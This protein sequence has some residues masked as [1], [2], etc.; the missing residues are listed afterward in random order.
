MGYGTAAYV[1]YVN[2]AED[3]FSSLVFAKARV[4]PLKPV[5]IPRLELAAA[6]LAVRVSRMVMRGWQRSFN[7]VNFWTDSAIVLYYINNKN[8]RFH[9]FVANR[10]SE[11][12]EHTR[13]KQWRHVGSENNPADK[14]SRGL[15]DV[16]SAQLWLDGPAFLRDSP[17]LWPKCLI[18]EEVEGAEEKKAA[19]HMSNVHKDTSFL[20]VFGR[21]STWTGLLRALAW[22]MRYKTYWMVMHRPNRGDSVR[23]GR[24]R[25]DEIRKAEKDLIILVQAEALSSEAIIAGGASNSSLQASRISKLRPRLINGLLCVGGRLT[26][27]SLTAESKHPIILPR[28]HFVTDLLIRYYHVMEGHAG[29]NHVLT[30][31]RQRFWILHGAETVKRTIRRCP[32]CRRQNAV[33]MRQLMAPLPAVRVREGWHP[34]SQV[35]LDYFGPIE[36]KRGRST[37]K[38]YGC[39]MTCLQSRAVHLELAHSMSTD[40]FIMLLMRFVG[41]RVPPTDLYS[42]NGSNFTHANKGLKEWPS[43]LDQQKIDAKSVA[44]RMQWHFNP[45]YASH[46]GG[47]WERLIRSV[48]RILSSVCVEQILD[49]EGL[50][51]VIVEAERILNNRPIAPVLHSD[52]EAAALTPN[53]LLLLRDNEGLQLKGTVLESYK[54]R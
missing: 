53:H 27:S 36:V 6:V 10:V 16:S 3:R 52:P 20:R 49:D 35:G 13:P 45:P 26:N 32:V 54:A 40:S 38:R 7:R 2:E 18:P 19:V 15:L 24:L 25:L 50:S 8:S 5:S 48:R 28:S 41:I 33:G 37:E 39:I 12:H 9:T 21:Y 47:V 4:A 11:I 51:S 44:R 30:A 14:V 17:A 46:R 22:L 42:D 1:C 23:I 34:F 43:N 31:V 29:V